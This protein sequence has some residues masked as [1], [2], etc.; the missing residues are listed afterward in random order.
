MDKI[1]ERCIF[2]LDG[3]YSDGVTAEGDEITPVNTEIE[4][5]AA[6]PIK[7]HVILIDDARL[8]NGVTGYPP[9]A[10]FKKYAVEKFPNHNFSIE[11]DII[12]INP[13]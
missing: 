13:K 3:H 10:D 9:I 8:F 6:H 7:N 11:H 2:W 1:E 5:I 4:V 12:V